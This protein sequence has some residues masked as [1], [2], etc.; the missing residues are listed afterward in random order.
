MSWGAAM[1]INPTVQTHVEMA[2]DPLKGMAAAHAF[3]DRGSLSLELGKLVPA[4]ES[5]SP[6][7]EVK[8]RI[9]GLFATASVD[10]WL[11]AVHSF[12]ISTSLTTTSD[13]WA[14]VV[15]YYS[16]HYSVRA[17]AHLLGY[18]QLYTQ[19]R[20]VKYRFDNGR[21]LCDYTKKKGADREHTA[22]WRL[23]KRDPLFASDQLFTENVSTGNV[24]ADVA[25]RDRA[26]YIDHLGAFPTFK[27][28]NATE[29]K[30]RIDRISGIEFTIP[31]I[32]DVARYPDVESVQIIAYHRLVRYRD[33]VDAILGGNNRFWS[34][35]RSPSWAREYVNYQLTE[36]ASLRSQFS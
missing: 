14:S 34:V 17:L 20:I 25:H 10:M 19:K 12:L 13:I 11:R 15:G 32:P 3:P 1:K 16:S 36:Q 35:H 6:T 27:P 22:Y 2:F 9:A 26:N 18:F 31:P 30:N 28:L 4:K 33:L 7:V 29:L 24:S 8:K 5:S 21:Y 23:V